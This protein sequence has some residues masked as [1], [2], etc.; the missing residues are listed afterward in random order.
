[1]IWEILSQSRFAK[2]AKIRNSEESKP[3]SEKGRGVT[4]NA[5]VTCDDTGS[6]EGGAQ[7]GGTIGATP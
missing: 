5:F 2:R 7:V 3:C 4:G 6:E 1:M